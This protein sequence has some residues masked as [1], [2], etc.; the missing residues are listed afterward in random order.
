MKGSEV[1]D[2][3]DERFATAPVTVRIIRSCRSA[4][5]GLQA[6]DLVSRAG[7]ERPDIVDLHVRL[8]LPGK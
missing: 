6:H 8:S 7:P 4:E 2:A 3:R 5:D 1:G